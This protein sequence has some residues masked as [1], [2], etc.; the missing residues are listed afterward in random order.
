MRASIFESEAVHSAGIRNKA[1]DGLLRPPRKG[2]DKI[3]LEDLVPILY[4]LNDSFK[5]KEADNPNEKRA[6]MK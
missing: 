3:L 6:W 4:M 2:A 1:V 5:M